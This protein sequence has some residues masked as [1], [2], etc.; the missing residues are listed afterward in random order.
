MSFGYK[1]CFRLKYGLSYVCRKLL[2]IYGFILQLESVPP[3]TRQWILLW[4]IWTIVLSLQG[5]PEEWVQWIIIT[6]LSLKSQRGLSFSI[7][8][9]QSSWYITVMRTR[10]ARFQSVM[11]VLLTLAIFCTFKVPNGQQ[12]PH[13][14]THH[15]HE[16]LSEDNAPVRSTSSR[17]PWAPCQYSWWCLYRGCSGD[18][19]DQVGVPRQKHQL[20]EGSSS[21]WAERQSLMRGEMWSVP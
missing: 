4:A 3:Y 5:Y 17:Y 6:E 7:L 9:R 14:W 8:K 10:H 20:D 11:L 19:L 1:S 12:K 21:Y 18:H 15:H 16:P 13:P 2:C